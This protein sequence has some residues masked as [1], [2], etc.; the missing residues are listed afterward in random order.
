[1]GRRSGRYAADIRGEYE[2][3]PLERYGLGARSGEWW[4]HVWRFDVAKNFSS[5]T[6]GD[7][8]QLSVLGVH[9]LPKEAIAFL[10][11]GKLGRAIDL[12]QKTRYVFFQGRNEFVS[13]A[14]D[15]RFSL[16]VGSAEFVEREL[17]RRTDTPRTTALQQNYPNPFNPSTIIRYELARA[18]NVEL[19]V[20]DVS[21]ALVKT[22]ESTYRVPGRYEVGWDGDNEAGQNVS[23]GIYFYR[24]ATPWT[25][26]TRKMTLIK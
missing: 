20:Y 1:W 8:V 19:K 3:L 25:T 2:Q 24:L 23:S 15:A 22:L 5:D 16:V 18:G 4:G 14:D 26:Q 10:I 9:D 12:G 13:S 6:A 7:E 11:D 17:D 21:G